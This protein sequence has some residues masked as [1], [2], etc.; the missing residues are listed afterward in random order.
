ME[1]NVRFYH[2]AACG[3]VIGLIHGNKDNLS[4]CGNKMECM[5]ANITDAA[6]EKHVPI[7]VVEGNEIKVQVGEVFHPMEEDHYIAWIALVG[8]NQTI[9]IA[10]KPGEEP[11]VK[12]K[13]I[14][15]SYLY[16]YC[17]KHG[18]WKTEVK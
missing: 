5:H 11:V 16:A 13:Y 7:Y 6:Q 9:R 3:N 12:M 10:L 18:L 1:E 4:C 17:N 15:N 14:P 8:E 2:C